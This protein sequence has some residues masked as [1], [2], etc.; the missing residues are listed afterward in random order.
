[1]MI[2]GKIWVA[3]RFSGQ[4][5]QAF[6][7]N[8]LKENFFYSHCSNWPFTNYILFVLASSNSF[9]VWVGL[10]ERMPIDCFTG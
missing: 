2:E 8:T 7:I 3:E 5:G 4:S 6:T 1:M 9:R 10:K